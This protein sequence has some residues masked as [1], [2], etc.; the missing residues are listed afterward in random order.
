MVILLATVVRT[1]ESGGPGR[2]CTL[3]NTGAEVS[4][5]RASFSVA[6]IARLAAKRCSMRSSWPAPTLPRN[7][8]GSATPQSTTLASPTPRRVDDSPSS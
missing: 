3:H 8:P 1:Q 6:K 7:P 4:V 5:V 2:R